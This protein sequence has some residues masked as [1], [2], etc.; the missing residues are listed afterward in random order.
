MRRVTQFI[1]SLLEMCAP[2][3]EDAYVCTPANHM[4]RGRACPV[5]A[6]NGRRARTR[7]SAMRASLPCLPLGRMQP[8]KR[9]RPSIVCALGRRRPCC[10]ARLYCRARPTIV[11]APRD[12]HTLRARPT[13]CMPLQYKFIKIVVHSTTWASR[14]STTVR[15]MT[16]GCLGGD[17]SF[18]IHSHG[19][20]AHPRMRLYTCLI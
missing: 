4:A 14:P 11:R 17:H 10:R 13:P 20:W 16:A 12:V 3:L 2:P 6:S 9:A 1:P 7:P 8:Y 18:L 19:P 15:W 5:C